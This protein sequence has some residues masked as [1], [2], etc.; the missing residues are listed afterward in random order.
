MKNKKSRPSYCIGR[1][2][3]LPVVPPKFAGVQPASPA[4]DKALPL[5]ARP[6]APLLPPGGCPVR[7]QLATR[8]C[9]S[10]GRWLPGFHLPRLAVSAV[11]RYFSPSRFFLTLAQF[12]GFVNR[13][14]EK[15]TKSER[16]IRAGCGGGFVGKLPKNH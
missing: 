14:Q 15:S 16:K 11:L 4:S 3:K 7:V 1:T 5:N 10:R 9:Y 13:K 6:T 2:A 12:G 8:E